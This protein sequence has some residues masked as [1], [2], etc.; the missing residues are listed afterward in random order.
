M[1]TTDCWPVMLLLLIVCFKMKSFLCKDYVN[2]W[3]TSILLIGHFPAP[4][5]WPPSSASTV[6]VFLI[7]R[8][9]ERGRRWSRKKNQGIYLIILLE[10]KR[11]EKKT[12]SNFS[13]FGH[14][15]ANLFAC[16]GGTWNQGLWVE[17]GRVVPARKI[18]RELYSA[19]KPIVIVT[20]SPIY[21]LGVVCSRNLSQCVCVKHFCA[22]WMYGII[23]YF[24]I[25]QSLKSQLREESDCDIE[26]VQV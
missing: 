20:C 26:H 13:I 25:F 7:F 23:Y 9:V 17:F 22:Y 24:L 3:W 2:L 21:P 14:W 19:H 4:R 12:I 8:Y 1:V 5:G 15:E 6:C 16:Q 11:N 18:F 10:C